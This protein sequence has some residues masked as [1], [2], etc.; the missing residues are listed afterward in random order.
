MNKKT[1]FLVIELALIILTAIILIS[2]SLTPKVSSALPTNTNMGCYPENFAMEPKPEL[3]WNIVKVKLGKGKMPATYSCKNSLIVKYSYQIYGDN[4]NPFWK[5]NNDNNNG[6]EP[7]YSIKYGDCLISRD[8]ALKI[9]INAAKDV[10]HQVCESDGLP[11]LSLGQMLGKVTYSNGKVISDDRAAKDYYPNVEDCNSFESLALKDAC[12]YAKS[13]VMDHGKGTG[14]PIC[15]SGKIKGKV[16][17]S[18]G[19]GLI[20]VPLA[21]IPLAQKNKQP[22]TCVRQI[23]CDEVGGSCESKS[24]CEFSSKGIISYGYGC[25]GNNVCCFDSTMHI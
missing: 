19:L 7:E 22:F 1:I 20:F 13:L 14:L 4:S 5:D 23:G 8:S 21:V 10:I 11:P 9:D 12:K 18:V 15:G 25:G 6:I 16:M 2:I 17:K 3:K 24:N